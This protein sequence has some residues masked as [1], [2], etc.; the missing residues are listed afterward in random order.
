MT[1]EQFAARLAK[2]RDQ[3]T[4]SLLKEFG[5]KD[6]DEAKSFF[7][8][9]QKEADAKKTEAQLMTEKLAKMEPLA[10]KAE[11]YEKAIA[12][13]LAA[14]EALIPEDK[15]ALLELAPPVENPQARL[16]WISKAKAK[17]LF[18]ADPAPAAAADATKTLATTRA[19]SGPPPPPAPPP[20][21]KHPREMSPEEFK[22]YESQKLGEHTVR[23]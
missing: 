17:N 13:Y 6:P 22:R 15:K 21:A 7:S 8:T 12:G 1:A 11:S 23:R 9:A 4:K 3:G 5:F 19:G 2:E 14:E 18:A 20:G 16:D 10:S